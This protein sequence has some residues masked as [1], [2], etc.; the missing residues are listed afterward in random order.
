MFQ[1]TIQ[2]YNKLR[3]YDSWL[4]PLLDYDLREAIEEMLYKDVDGNWT[5]N[6]CDFK[7]PYKTTMNNH[8]EAK[9]I[10]AIDG[11]ACDICNRHCPTKNALKCHKYREHNRK[12]LS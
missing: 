4:F 11:Y 9:H 3:R 6:Q 7:T 8:V 1:D 12:L 10:R 5:C 2:K